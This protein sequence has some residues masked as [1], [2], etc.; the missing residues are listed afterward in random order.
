[1]SSLDSPRLNPLLIRVARRLLIPARTLVVM[2]RVVRER[3]RR[4]LMASEN[5]F[6]PWFRRDDFAYPLTLSG[7]LR[8]SKMSLSRFCILSL[9]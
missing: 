7:S 9:N 5:A 2:R 4:P 6:R 8:C 1:M 3:V